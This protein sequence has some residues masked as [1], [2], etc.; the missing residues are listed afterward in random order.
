MKPVGD[1][2]PE[3]HQRHRTCLDIGGVEHREIAAVSLRARPPPAAS[4]RPRRHPA[5]FDE[6]GFRDGVAGRRRYFPSRSP[7][8]DMHDAG[9]RTEHR[10]IKLAQAY[11]PWLEASPAR[12]SSMRGNSP[13]ISSR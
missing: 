5:A 3:L 11:Q 13:V 9:E 2:M 8:V 1:A 4:R 12:R 7:A 10:Q 6:H